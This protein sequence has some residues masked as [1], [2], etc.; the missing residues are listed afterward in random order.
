[1][2]TITDSARVL[3]HATGLAISELGAMYSW[4]SWTFGWLLRVLAQII[5]YTLIGVLLDDPAIVQFLL[6]GNVALIAGSAGMFAIA[7]TQWE[8]FA[9]TLPLLVAAPSRIMWVYL[10][11]SVEWLA[12]GLA[13]SVLGLLIVGPMFDITLTPLQILQ[14]IPLLLVVV[15]ATYGMGT[16][17]GAV[18]LQNPDLRNVVLNL[19]TGTMAIVTGA[20][21]PVEFLA[22]PIQWFGQIFPLTHGLRAIRET[23]TGARWADI[24]PDLGLCIV[25][26]LIWMGIAAMTFERFAESGRQDGSIEFGD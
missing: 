11:R 14:V 7:S 21:F 22:S 2:T 18:V 6:I 20:N 13:T 19:A 3:R 23:I 5:F 15:V 26:G 24:A 10:G 4:Q 1:M 25:V 16:F 9:G 8:R 17:L 12:D